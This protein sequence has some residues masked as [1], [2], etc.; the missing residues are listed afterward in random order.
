MMFDLL[1]TESAYSIYGA[2]SGM[3]LHNKFNQTLLVI[4]TFSINLFLI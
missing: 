2:S 1:T 4:I 3:S